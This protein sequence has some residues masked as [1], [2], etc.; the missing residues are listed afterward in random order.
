M[1]DEV[2]DP[3]QDIREML[4]ELFMLATKMRKVYSET[5]RRHQRYVGSAPT[6][7]VFPRMDTMLQKVDDILQEQIGVIFDK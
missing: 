3:R 7:N 4:T 2:Y 1:S 5:R 6:W